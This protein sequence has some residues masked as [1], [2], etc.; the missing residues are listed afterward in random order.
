MLG[1][2]FIFFSI[3]MICAIVAMC[4]NQ[5]RHG[6]ILL[7]SALASLVVCGILFFAL[8]VGTVG[9]AAQKAAQDSQRLQYQQ[10]GTR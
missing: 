4:T 2:G 3:T 1:F 6:L 8:I 10:P 5:V 9:A 7:L